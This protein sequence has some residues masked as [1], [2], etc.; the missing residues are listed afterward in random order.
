[1]IWGTRG[2][3][4]SY[5]GEAKCAQFLT[6]STKHAYTWATDTWFTNG[7]GFRSPSSEQYYEAFTDTA[8]GGAL[9]DMSDHITRPSAQR[10]Q[11]LHA[12]SIIAVKYLDGSE[13]G[14][15]GHMMMV[16]SIAP[17]ERDG[18]RA[19]QEYAVTVADSTSNPHGVAF[20]SKTS[21]HWAFRDTRVEGSPGL[22]TKERSGAGRG[23]IF[24][25]ADATTSRPTGY[26]WGRNETAFNTVANRPMVFV[27][28][29]R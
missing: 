15:T 7:T 4:R 6:A 19:T 17:F 11:D 27:D 26:W 8:A 18:N 13:G 16:E 21:P 5:Q 3:A 20:S 25:Q 22:T 14:A 24:I 12:G 23:T 2:N 28:V 10:V 9:E 29:T 1:M